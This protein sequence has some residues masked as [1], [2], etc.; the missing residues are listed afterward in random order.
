MPDLK[1]NNNICTTKCVLIGNSFPMNLVQRRVT[2]TP[3][4][5][6]NIRRVINNAETILSFWGHNNTV[7]IVSQICGINLQPE[8]DRPCLNLTD[9]KF[10]EF[11]GI[12]FDK[13]W[14]VVPIYQKKF[15]PEIG[16]EISETDIKSWQILKIEFN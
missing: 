13:C 11:S 3:K 16:E 5:I 8:E 14:I 12:E 4:T 9:N 6:D 10:I 1:K 15:R 7:K 2:I